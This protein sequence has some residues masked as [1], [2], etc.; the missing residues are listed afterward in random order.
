MIETLG[1]VRP[2][3]KAILDRLAD[4]PVDIEPRFVTA[5]ALLQER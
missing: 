5:Q 3:V 1:V 4:V 2:P